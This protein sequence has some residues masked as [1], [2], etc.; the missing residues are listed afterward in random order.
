MSMTS[1]ELQ[2]KLASGI[3]ALVLEVPE[4][5]VPKKEKQELLCPQ[6]VCL[7]DVN[8]SL[9]GIFASAECS[10]FTS[11]NGST[12]GCGLNGDGQ[13]GLGYISMAVHRLQRIPGASNARWLGGG[14][15]NSAALIKEK[16]YTWGKAEE[17]GHGLDMNAAPVLE[18]KHVTDLPAIRTLRCGGSHMLACSE[19]GDVFVWGC[20]LTHQLANRPRDV[21]DPADKDDEPGDELRPYRVSSKQ[22][23]SRFVLLADGGAQHSVE[24]AWNGDYGDLADIH[25]L[26]TSSAVQPRIEESSRSVEQTELE[27]PLKKRTVGDSHSDAHPRTAIAVTHEQISRTAASSAAKA[28]ESPTLEKIAA[29]RAAIAASEIAA[30]SAV[31]TQT[32]LTAQAEAEVLRCFSGRL[33]SEANEEQPASVSSSSRADPATV[34]WPRGQPVTA[35]REAAVVRGQS[36]TVTRTPAP[37]SAALTNA[38]GELRLS[39][40]LACLSRNALEALLVKSALRDEPLR[41]NVQRLCESARASDAEHPVGRS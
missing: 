25:T 29:A 4:R 30:S 16:V 39:A 21:S 31:Q 5:E 33:L 19:A 41:E 32:A 23:E 36:E 24:L 8:G 12:Y 14:L 20:G 13:V 27:P 34:L 7:A 18:P 10:F 38:G 40:Q 11:D 35:L 9:T 2:Q 28:V 22:L 1:S 3:S 17:C 6:E 26:G 37:S 15:H